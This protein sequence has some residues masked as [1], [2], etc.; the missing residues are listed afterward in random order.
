[1]IASFALSKAGIG[2][3]ILKTLAG[4]DSKP[5]ELPHLL[6]SKDKV[7][8]PDADCGEMFTPHA[9]NPAEANDKFMKWLKGQWFTPSDLQEKFSPGEMERLFVPFWVF[10][11]RTFTQFSADVLVPTEQYNGTEVLL[12]PNKQLEA[13]DTVQKEWIHVT[14]S[15]EDSYDDILIPA[16]DHPELLKWIKSFSRKNWDWT[17]AQ[18]PLS[19]FPSEKRNTIPPPLPWQGIWTSHKSEIDKLETKKCSRLFERE[20]AHRKF[21]RVKH[22]EAHP[23]YSS[24]KRRLVYLP[25]YSIDY[26]Y[27]EK[28]YRAAVHGL[29]SKT[30]GDRPYGM[31]ATLGALTKSAKKKS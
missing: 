3:S 12:Q 30:A 14:G 17:A 16:T 29:T 24:F 5:K 23:I 7:G 21:L 15:R 13:D 11:C 28:I 18:T 27:A 31:G 22:V 8:D 1:M 6:T 19:Q 2:G 25:L 9:L 26:C 20:S 4:G 10:A